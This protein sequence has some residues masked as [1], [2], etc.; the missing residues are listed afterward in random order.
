MPRKD[1]DQLVVLARSEAGDTT[2][3]KYVSTDGGAT[4]NKA[5]DF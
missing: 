2:G 5:G 4:W 3:V 1:K